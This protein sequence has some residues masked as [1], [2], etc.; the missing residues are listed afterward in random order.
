M[1][2][3]CFSQSRLA[4]DVSILVQ[5]EERSD[6]SM[7]AQLHE[8][9]VKMCE[10]PRPACVDAYTWGL[11]KK[12]DKTVLIALLEARMEHMR[13]SVKVKFMFVRVEAEE[14]GCVGAI[15][16]IGDWDESR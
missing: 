15:G 13:D 2:R 7:C 8:S 10:I 14:R 5:L 3:E 16:F 4:R 12:K 11:W 9:V 6:E 1:S